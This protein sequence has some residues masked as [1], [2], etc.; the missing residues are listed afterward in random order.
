ME[1]NKKSTS[2]LSGE[3]QRAEEDLKQGKDITNPDAIKDPKKT[4]SKVEPKERS[5]EVL[6]NYIN[7]LM[8]PEV[9]NRFR[10]IVT[11]RQGED[12]RDGLKKPTVGKIFS[13]MVSHFEKKLKI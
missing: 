2:W 7:I 5:K 3:E 1:E 6:Y 10:Y 13:E 4:G 8:D 11:L 12:L 9:E